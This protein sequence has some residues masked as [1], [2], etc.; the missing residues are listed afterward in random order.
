MF[1]RKPHPWDP[2]YALPANVLAE[3]PGRGTLT[4]GYM[5]RK[6]ID[7][8]AVPPPWR[9]GYAYPDYVGK[10]PLGR[11]VYRTKYMPRKTVS[12]LIP[13]YLGGLGDV[14]YERDPIAIFG[15]NVSAHLMSS[16]YT[17][18]P[19]L[20]KPALRALFDQ[21]DP[22]LWGRVSAKASKL[23]RERDMGPMEALEKAIA[24][25][26]SMG[27]LEEF[28]A[29][30][31]GKTPKPKSFLGLGAYGEEA[32]VIVL[33][34]AMT[35]LGFCGPI[36]LAKK[37]GS[38]IKGAV[39]GIGGALKGGAE[40]VGG[41]ASS[42]VKAIGSLAC[43]VAGSGLGQ[44]AAAAGAMAAGAPPQ[45]GAKGAEV[46]QGMCGQKG[47]Q[48]TMPPPAAKAGIPILP[49]AIGGAALVAVVLLAR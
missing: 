7:A 16:I 27:L 32:E 8:P 38:G 4:T 42:A 37:A 35:A 18:P 23:M 33:E 25:S 9:T 47:V 30:G 11:G 45:V 3:P 44:Q 41:W 5:R 24:A 20:R 15:R 14:D 34:G 17:L 49:I 21:I 2:G 29:L 13:K 6:T 31:R 39:T 26:T 46:M 36:C 28:I 48:P 43:G 10:E 19:N 12:T 22:K 40:Q 1:F